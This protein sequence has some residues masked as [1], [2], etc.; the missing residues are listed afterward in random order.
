MCCH[1]HY[2][3]RGDCMGIL[4]LMNGRIVFPICNKK[5]ERAPH[6]FGHTF[7][8][9]WRCTGIVLGAATMF[10]LVKTIPVVLS[11]QTFVLA[12]TCMIPMVCDGIMQYGYRVESTN[13]RRVFTGLLFGAGT[14]CVI[15]FIINN[16]ESLLSVC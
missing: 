15:G 16:A 6:I 8:L 4:E 12:L 14:V 7:V 13:F 3:Y 11:V 10:F 1:Y 5:P 2:R 9:C